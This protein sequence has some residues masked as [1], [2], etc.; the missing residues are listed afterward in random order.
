VPKSE[1]KRAEKQKPR[2]DESELG[3]EGLKRWETTNWGETN[4]EKKSMWEMEGTRS[5]FRTF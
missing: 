1:I 2:K 3:V 4:G 5:D